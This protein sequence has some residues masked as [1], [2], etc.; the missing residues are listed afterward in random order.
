MTGQLICFAAYL[1]YMERRHYG[2]YALSLVAYSAGL[3]HHQEIFLLPIPLVL[4]YVL[5]RCHSIKD[6]VRAE[7][8]LQFLPLAAIT[9]V[10]LFVQ[11]YN[12]SES[13][14]DQF[15][16]P[17]TQAVEFFLGSLAI[18]VYPRNFVDVGWSHLSI[19]IVLVLV[20]GLVAWKRPQQR[21]ILAVMTA[22]YAASLAL[23]VVFFGGA[24]G[25]APLAVITRKIY[26]AGPALAIAAAVCLDALWSLIRPRIPQ[27][28]IVVPSVVLGIVALALAFEIKQDLVGPL[29]AD[30]RT[31]KSFYRALIQQYPQLPEGS[32]LYLAGTPPNLFFPACPQGRVVRAEPPRTV[33]SF[34]YLDN[35]IAAMY[36]VSVQPIPITREQARDPAYVQSLGN[37]AAVFCYRCDDP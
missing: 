17:T 9:L 22:W 3:L 27:S 5:T 35:L 32:V 13:G 14:F 29:A 25:S 7:T 19:D 10:F 16:R 12:T 34:C 24:A 36:G 8:W 18:S 33:N 2:W 28:L 37:D 6:V 21:V 15:F 1:K 4:W 11:G 20:L 30:A 26:S 31:N 23:S